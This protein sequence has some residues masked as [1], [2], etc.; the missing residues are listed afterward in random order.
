M[1]GPF[2]TIGDLTLQLM[3]APAT[4]RERAAFEFAEH[5]VLEGKPKLQAI[6]AKLQDLQL[7]F[8][9]H[10]GQVDI[11][12]IA[13]R[14]A[15]MRD[16]AEVVAVTMGDGEYLGE[17]VI[18][19]VTFDRGATFDNGTALTATMSVTLREY[20]AAAA[21][22]V[23]DRPAVAKGNPTKKKDGGQFTRD[24]KT[25]ELVPKGAG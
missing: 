2:C 14:V 18:V 25:G 16:G 22:V 4:W 11:G 20:V 23:T 12:F 10:A 15:E 5:P 3:E 1:A 7:E 8:Q 9:F 17:F 24:P 21:L 13:N 19:D 6:G